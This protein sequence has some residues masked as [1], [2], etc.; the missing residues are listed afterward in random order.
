MKIAVLGTGAV[1]QTIARRLGELGHEVTV[2]AR[3]AD[4]PS[5]EPFSEFTGVA[6]GSFAD[7]AA[8]S[9]LVFSCVNGEHTLA[10]L[11]AAGADNLAG[12]TLVDTGNFLDHSGEGMP[13]PGATLDNCLGAQ[14]QERFPEARV[15]KSLNT[16]NN[17][18]MVDPSIVEGDHSVFVSG[19]D[20][21]AKDQLKGLLKEFGWRDI[22]IVDLGGIKTA[23]AA[24]MLMPLWIDLVIARGGFGAGPFNIGVHSA[25]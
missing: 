25:V 12:K 6:A 8:A 18:V 7:A 19:D 11:E 14:I 5:L 1:G 3:S 24:E 10:A 22:Q 23:A 17:Q 21:A 4:S 16:M 15:V 13:R 9:E 2:G 20:A